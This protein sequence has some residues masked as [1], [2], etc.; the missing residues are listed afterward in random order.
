MYP[1]SKTCK[2]INI[3]Q[4][5]NR[6]YQIDTNIYFYSFYLF[7]S[8]R[9]NLYIVIFYQLIYSFN[10]SQNTQ[11]NFQI[12]IIYLFVSQQTL[13]NKQYRGKQECVPEVIIY[14][15]FFFVNLD[16][17]N[18]LKNYS[19]LKQIFYFQNEQSLFDKF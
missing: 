12:L 17:M 13:F 2:K 3:L 6:F 16:I 19:F 4:L 14:K 5:Y 8:L 7:T 11:K 10:F 15:K 9:N 1:S 18:L